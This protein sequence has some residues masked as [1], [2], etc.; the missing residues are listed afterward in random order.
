[1][2]TTL[3][4]ISHDGKGY[5][6]IE[7]ASLQLDSATNFDLYIRARAG[8]PIVLYAK[9]NTPF[10]EDTLKRLEDNQVESL[11]INAEQE[12]AYALYLEEHLRQILSDPTVPDVEKA[13]IL[14]FSAHGLVKE[15]LQNPQLEGGLERGKGIVRN[16]VNFLFSKQSSLRHLI[17]T[18]SF[19]YFTYTHSVSACVFGIALAQRLGVG[20]TGRLREFGN[21]AL[22]RDIGTSQIDPTIAETPGQLS[23]TQYDILKQHPVLGEQILIEMGGMSDLGLDIVRHHH[24]KMDGTGYPDG[25]WGDEINSFSRICTIA[26]VFDALTTNRSYRKAIGTFEALKLMRN[27]MR[28]E[29]DMDFLRVFIELMGNPG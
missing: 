25:L 13:A 24:E 18:A 28:D 17:Q 29:I 3:K 27:E 1:M 9:R 21:G 10:T 22:L 12:G 16:T 15:V 19:D 2:V 4:K 14:H 5:I 26:D 23:S 11:F 7:V 8:E 20:G 6:P